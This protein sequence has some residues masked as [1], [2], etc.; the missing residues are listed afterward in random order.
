MKRNNTQCFILFLFLLFLS[1][2]CASLPGN[3]Q[4]EVST[5]YLDTQNTLIGS[6]V[7]A[8]LQAY[9]G[10]SAYLLL[11]NGLDAFVARAVLAQIA[12]RSIDTQYYLI[13]NDVVGNLFLDQLIK[14]AD[15]GV[16]VRLLVDDIDQQGRD[17]GAA[18]LNSHP[19]IAVRVFNP[20]ARNTGRTLQYLT[21]FG[22]KTRR[23]HN[24][25]F[26]VDN[27]ATILGGA[28][29]WQRV[30][31]G[32]PGTGLRRSRCSCGRAGGWAGFRILRSVL[33][34][35]TELSHLGSGG[36]TTHSPGDRSAHT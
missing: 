34:Q 15:R 30:L 25:S 29:Y 13:H 24:K 4:K 9:P 31:R 6:R 16:R 11:G 14:A 27:Q 35:R 7:Q 20:F 23:A 21:S 28:Q 26:T 8:G 5:A 2:G 1:G 10:E 32:R 12:E 17:F 3:L 33:E 36:R 19:N 22:K 18:V